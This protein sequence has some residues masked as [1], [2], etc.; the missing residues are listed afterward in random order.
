VK[1]TVVKHYAEAFLTCSMLYA[2]CYPIR[3]DIDAA[4]ALYS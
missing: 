4:R 1:V 2:I 3:D